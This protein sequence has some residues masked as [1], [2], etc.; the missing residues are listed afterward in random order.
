MITLTVLN[1]VHCLHFLQ[2]EKTA[3]HLFDAAYFGQEDDI[4]GVSE[5]I[6]S[7]VAMKLGTGFFDLLYSPP[8]EV[9]ESLA[10][11]QKKPLFDDPELHDPFS[12]DIDPT[13]GP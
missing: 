9:T 5:S 10:Q 12:F 11:G 13:Q 6:I 7:G 4:V 2:F 3:D 8:V 1:C